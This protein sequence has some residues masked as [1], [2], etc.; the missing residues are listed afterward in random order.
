MSSSVR[1]GQDQAKV[2]KV[3]NNL[4]RVP[5]DWTS[6]FVAPI[7]KKGSRTLPFNYRPVSLTCITSKIFECIIACNDYNEALRKQ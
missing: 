1:I 6:G 3:R 2:E 5:V 4:N 7:F